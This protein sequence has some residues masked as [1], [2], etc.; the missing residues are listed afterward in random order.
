MIDE[1]R[2]F[3]IPTLRQLFVRIFHKTVLIDALIGW[4]TR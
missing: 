1:Y 3:G 4:P 2:R